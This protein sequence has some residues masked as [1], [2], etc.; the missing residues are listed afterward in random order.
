MTISYMQILHVLNE[1]D[2]EGLFKTGAPRDE[3]ES[4]AKLIAQAVT[5]AGGL[6]ITEERLA[7]LV[8]DA[9]QRMF[10]LSKEQSRQRREAF[11]RVAQRILAVHQ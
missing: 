10:G 4:E 7:A 3:Y 8:G 9:W 11:Q 5:Q 2:I 6:P 1:E